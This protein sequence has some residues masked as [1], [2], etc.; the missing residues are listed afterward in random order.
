MTGIAF[1][2]L[3]GGPLERGLALLLEQIHAAGERAL[4]LAATAERVAALNV[5][6]W[7]YRPD[8]FLP[9][10]AAADGPAADGPADE[11]PIWLTDRE[12]NPNRATALV[13]IEGREWAD[14]ADFRECYYLFDRNDDTAREEARDRWRRYREGGHQLAYWE[15]SAAGW[16][17]QS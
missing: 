2:N 9:H 5:A 4:V 10:G 16:R 17:G 15:Q 3:A 6:L 13:L 14:L 11:Q 7:T 12:E 1:C 8:S